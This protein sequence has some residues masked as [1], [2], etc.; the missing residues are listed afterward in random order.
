MNGHCAV[1]GQYHLELD[2]AHVRDKSDFSEEEILDGI[3]RLLNIIPMCKHHH[4]TDFDHKRKIGLY[5]GEKNI[6]FTRYNHCTNGICL[7]ESHVELVNLFLESIG[8]DG[9]HIEQEYIQ[10]KNA[11]LADPVHRDFHFHLND[12]KNYPN[13]IPSSYCKGDEP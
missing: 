11:R 2:G 7:T 12:P 10:W 9:S 13:S 6:I 4:Q 1:C 5:K 3:D 8:D